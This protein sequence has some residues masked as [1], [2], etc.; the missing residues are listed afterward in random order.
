[1]RICFI[2]AGTLGLLN[3]Q[4]FTDPIFATPTEILD[5]GNVDSKN[6]PGF[7]TITF[8]NTGGAPLLITNIIPSCGCTVP[9]WPKDAIK[10]GQSSEIKVKYDISRIGLIS[11]TITI[12]TNEPDGKEADGKIIY[13]QYVIPVKGT[14]K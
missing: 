1:M 8:T 11:K 10:P 9:E 13:K 4:S 7:R 5:F 2:I 14:V 12:V 3:A 6:D